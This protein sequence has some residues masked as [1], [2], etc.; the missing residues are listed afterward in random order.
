MKGMQKDRQCIVEKE[1][2]FRKVSEY[3]NEVATYF[4]FVMYYIRLWKLCCHNE[5]KRLIPYSCYTCLKA[6]YE[7]LPMVEQI[8][9]DLS[10]SVLI[11]CEL[12]CFRPSVVICALFTQSI[13]LYLHV[14]VSQN[15]EAL[16]DPIRLQEFRIFNQVWDSIVNKLFGR[17]SLPYI[18]SFGSYILSRQIRLSNLLSSGTHFDKLRLDN[19]YKQRTKP[20]YKAKDSHRSTLLDYYDFNLEF[21]DLKAQYQRALTWAYKVHN[22][23]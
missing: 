4:D 21:N 15:G 13:E 23:K 8:C 19:I 17:S 16:A 7:M 14:H 10:K 18:E 11:D 2:E 1:I 6:S 12:M 5:M 20:Y 22:A 9:Y 3:E